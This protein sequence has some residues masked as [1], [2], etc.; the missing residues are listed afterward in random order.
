MGSV[1][2]RKMAKL[3]E[4]VNALPLPR[5]SPRVD[6]TLI[7]ACALPCTP[8]KGMYR[9]HVDMHARLSEVRSPSRHWLVFNSYV[10]LR[11]V[12]SMLVLGTLFY[13]M[14]SGDHPNKDARLAGCSQLGEGRAR[15]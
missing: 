11:A 9:H 13:A 1:P 10:T 8:G 6:S 14:V 5:Q 3:V 15:V 7:V 4:A 12:T 2:I